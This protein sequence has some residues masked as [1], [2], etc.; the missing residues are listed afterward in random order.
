MSVPFSSRWLDWE[1]ETPTQATAKTDKTS[2]LG[3]KRRLLKQPIA[4]P[5]LTYSLDEVHQQPPR[6]TPGHLAY[7]DN[8]VDLHTSGG[9]SLEEARRSALAKTLGQGPMRLKELGI[10]RDQPEEGTG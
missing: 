10:R 7:F 6:L 2:F 5:D 1:P 9:Y 3:V 8:W 4:A